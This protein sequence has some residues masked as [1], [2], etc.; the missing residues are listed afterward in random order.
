[1]SKAHIHLI[2]LC[3]GAESFEDQQDWIKARIAAGGPDYLPNHTTRMWPKQ[4]AQILQG[5]SLYWVIKGFIQARQRII[6]LEEVTGI[7]GIRRCKIM[8][9]PELIRTTTVPRRPFQGWR[10]LKPE[11]AP[12]DLPKSRA[13]DDALP[14]DLA[15]AL[16]DIGLR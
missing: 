11:D 16:A 5:G 15:L 2:K 14:K 1:M 10:Y 8:M 7:D 12:T 9:D 4:E 13:T 6:R 3:V